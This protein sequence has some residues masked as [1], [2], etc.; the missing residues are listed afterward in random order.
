MKLDPKAGLV[1]TKVWA[2]P[3]CFNDDV[4]QYRI[5]NN[6][7]IIDVKPVDPDDYEH[8]KKIGEV[9]AKFD[10]I[11][12]LIFEDWVAVRVEGK[13]FTTQANERDVTQQAVSKNVKRATEKL[14]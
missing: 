8:L 2:C 4:D 13:M 5:E 6:Y 12:E 10:E 3:H 14:S 11:S 9:D 7:D 1:R